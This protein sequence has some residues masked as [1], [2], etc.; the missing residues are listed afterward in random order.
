[1]VAAL[2]VAALA[3]MFW[4]LFAAKLTQWRITA[5]MVV[6]AAGLAL[7]SV[8]R[9]TIGEALN[10]RVALRAA[11]IILAVL[12]FVDATEVKGGPLGKSPATVLR[13]LLIALP[14]SLAGALAFG[15]WLLPGLSLPV[16]LV[17]A[18]VVMPIDFAPAAPIL[19]DRR[20]SARLRNA[21]N[22]E[23][24]YNDGIVSPLIIFGLALAGD[25]AH[26]KSPL[27]ALAAA[28]P[29]AVKA[30]A[31]GLCVGALLAFL[32]N[33]AERANLMT[34][35]SKR[36]ALVAAPL[37]AYA[38]S[39]G[40]NGNGF[41]ASFVCG[42]VFHFV[43]RTTDSRRDLELLD[44][45]SFLLTVTMWLVFGS[46]AVF[47]LWGGVDWRMVVFCVAA[48]TVLRILPVLVSLLGSPLSG[49]ERLLV[50]VLGPR[51]TTSIIF[52]LLAFNA[53]ADDAALQVLTAM[54]VTIL[55]SVVLHGGGSLIIARGPRP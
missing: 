43:R 46:A 14:L 19:R 40:I 30:V 4:S 37:L 27:A 49:A 28:G 13:L 8:T 10:T 52:G 50:G 35:Q 41:V 51:G 31:V 7:G 25:T 29:A 55:G 54:V 17:I 9:N 16:L 53:L 32:V 48:L 47:A 23:S 24:G 21:L 5:P 3:L 20:I 45:V 36:L 12:L 1:M 34:A 38:V 39:V 15:W 26:A 18:C 42:F 6:V 33:N 22:V 2:V 11:E 44:D